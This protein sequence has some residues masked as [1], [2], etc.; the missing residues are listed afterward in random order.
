VTIEYD[1]LPF[2]FLGLDERGDDFGRAKALV[3]PVAYDHT[4]SYGTGSRKAPLRVIEASRYVEYYDEELGVEPRQAGI[5]TLP[6]MEPDVSGPEAMV[7]QVESAVGQILDLGKCPVLVGGEHSLSA[8][9][10]KA[11]AR[12]R[13][14]LSVLQ[15]DAHADLREAWQGSRFSH[16]C[17]AARMAELCPIL[18]IGIRAM[19]GDEHAA[20]RAHPVKTITAARF[21]AGHDWRAEMDAFLAPLVYVTVD[22]DVFDPS[23]LPATGTPEPGGLSWNQVLDVLRRVFATREVVGMD[24]VELEPIPGV[25]APDYAVAKL[26]HRM[27]GY[28]FFPGRIPA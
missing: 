13:P 12:R 5:H 17:V 2:N 22:V 25:S 15:L 9:A 28:R 20:A 8:G 21:H 16:A 14:G 27:I 18:Q 4:S 1:R 6:I 24:V 26:I 11:A 19:T 3:L 10:V 7:A 23:V